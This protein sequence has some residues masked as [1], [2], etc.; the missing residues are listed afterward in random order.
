MALVDFRLSVP[1]NATVHSPAL[2]PG[3]VNADGS[4]SSVLS[5]IAGQEVNLTLQA[6]DSRGIPAERC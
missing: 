4:M 1:K 5:A 3:Y 6:R 2:E